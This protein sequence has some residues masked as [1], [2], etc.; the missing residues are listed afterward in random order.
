MTS[1]TISEKVKTTADTPPKPNYNDLVIQDVQLGIWRAKIATKV[2]GL[3]YW[4][5]WDEVKVG[6]PQFRRLVKDIHGIAPR[7]ILI[8]LVCQIWNGLENAISMHFAS[9]LLQNVSICAVPRWLLLTCSSR[10]KARL[11][12][13]KLTLRAFSRPRSGNWF[14]LC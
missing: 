12:R 2:V 1:S 13:E 9:A 3:N 14:A 10:L 7:L 8:Y 5:Y 11:R 4:K 6:W